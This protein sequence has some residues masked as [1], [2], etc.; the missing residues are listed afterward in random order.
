MSRITRE[1]VEHTA[2]LARLRLEAGE[3][4]AMTRSLEA[5]LDYAALLDGIDTEGVEPTAHAIP[6]ATPF[7]DDEAR[8]TVAPERAVAG[9]PAHEGTAFSVPKVLDSEAEG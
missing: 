4:E 1:Q 3:A 2:G 6:L 8:D 7:R 9:A 5:I